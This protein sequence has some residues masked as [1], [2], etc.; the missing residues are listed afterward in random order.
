MSICGQ[1]SDTGYGRGSSANR[2]TEAVAAIGEL[3]LRFQNSPD[4][5]TGEL[6][7]FRIA[8][9]LVV[10]DQAL[11]HRNEGERPEGAVTMPG[12]TPQVQLGRYRLR[13]I[14]RRQTRVSISTT[15]ASSVPGNGSRGR[16]QRGHFCCASG[17]SAT[18]SRASSPSRRLRPCPRL[19][20]C[21]PRGRALTW[22]RDG[23]LPSPTL[24]SLR[25]P[26]RRPSN[27]RIRARNSSLSLLRSA[28]RSTASRGWAFQYAAAQRKSMCS[29]L[30][31]R[32]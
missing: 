9:N 10:L 29:S 12:K 16:P 15:W 2:S 19:P 8:R 13:R 24:R 28:S 25:R 18:S 32:I 30:S 21:C 3:P 7:G 22:P 5:P 31:T 27:S 14:T 20:G 17:R 4:Q 26:Y 1:S 23:F 6:K 11:H